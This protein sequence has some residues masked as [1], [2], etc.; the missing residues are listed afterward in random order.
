MFQATN[1]KEHGHSGGRNTHKSISIKGFTVSISMTVRNA[2]SDRPLM[3]AR[4]LPAAPQMTKSMRPNV[5]IVRFTAAWS[6]SGFRTSACAAIHCWPDAAESSFAVASSRSSLRSV[7]VERRQPS[8]YVE[9][10]VE[11]GMPYLRPTIVAE[12]PWRI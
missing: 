7:K 1:G 4:K 3:G 12:A 6:C 5:S 10:A 2:F 9:N 8:E 11:N